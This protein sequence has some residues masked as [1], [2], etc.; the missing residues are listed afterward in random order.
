[1]N[2]RDGTPLHPTSDA[3]FELEFNPGATRDGLIRITAKWDGKNLSI[4]GTEG[5]TSAGQI[6]GSLSHIETFMPGWSKDK[7][8]R[9]AALWTRWHLN[10]MRA[11]TPAQMAFLN[12]YIAENKMP[13]L[14]RYTWMMAALREVGLDKDDGYAYG[15]SWLF[16]EVPAEVINEIKAFPSIH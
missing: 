10:D 9:L 7:A 1:M 5:R 14:D 15:S 13:A 2:L 4:T 12:R 3:A 8:A 6:H 16:E 11:G